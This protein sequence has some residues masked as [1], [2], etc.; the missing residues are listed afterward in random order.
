MDDFDG[1][2]FSLNLSKTSKYLTFHIRDNLLKF[3]VNNSEVPILIALYVNGSLNQ[4]DLYKIYQLNDSTVAKALL[5]LEEKGFIER[6]I[7]PKDRRRKIVKLTSRGK[8]VSEKVLVPEDFF[9][10]MFK[11]FSKEE[12]NQLEYLFG[13]LMNNIDEV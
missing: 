5:R 12:L 9:N 1:I 6:E 11:N 7:N 2:E 13:K 4:E 10:K 8:D 3:N